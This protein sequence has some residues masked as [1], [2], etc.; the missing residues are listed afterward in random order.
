[1]A[2]DRLSKAASAVWNIEEHAWMDYELDG[3]GECGALIAASHE[4][5]KLLAVGEQGFTADTYNA[6]LRKRL[7][8]EHPKMSYR[9]YC[10]LGLLEIRQDDDEL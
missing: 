6:E 8:P 3:S 2:N 5:S 10:L 1:M 9:T 4:R 7:A